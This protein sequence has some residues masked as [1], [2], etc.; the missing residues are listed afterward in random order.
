MKIGIEAQRIFRKKKHGMD[1]VALEMIKELQIIDKENEYCIFIKHD[2]DNLCLKESSNLKIVE[3]EGK[4]YP[5]WEQR[6]LPKA[7]LKE[8]INILHCTSNTAPINCKIPLI[9]TLHDIIYLEQKSL[10]QK[11]GT[12]YQK[13]GNLY[14]K[15]IVPKIVNKCRKIITVSDFERNRIINQLGLNESRVI[16]VYNGISKHFKPVTDK[17]LLNKVGLKYNL[18]EDF[19]FFLGNTDPKKNVAGT[20]KGYALYLK[21]SGN[22]IPLVMLD[23]KKES[24]EK[25]L[26]EINETQI[27]D[28]IILPGYVYNIDLP[29]I[30]SLSKIFL[31]P[32]LRESFGIPPLE[33]MACGTP[34]LAS[35]TSS[36]P[37]VTGDAAYMV[38]PFKPEEIA[39]G[40]KTLLNDFLLREELIKRGFVRAS[41][42][43]WLSTAESVLKIYNSLIDDILKDEKLQ[44]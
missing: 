1:V 11:K 10:I 33:A 2:E 8:K 32:S 37:E 7:A 27:A 24:L 39:S 30:Y 17:L 6:C 5:Y 41:L 36:I 28:K 29:A 18:P 22:N 19:I 31:Y 40:I 26:S 35:N 23:Y 20:L 43:S 15:F 4:S 34:V 21:E 13:F 12:L 42:F 3:V 16:T 14:R 44:Q 25:T 9:L 38:N